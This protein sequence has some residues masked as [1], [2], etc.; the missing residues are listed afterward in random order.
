MTPKD[1]VLVAEEISNIYEKKT[2][3][4][5]EKKVK[6]IR[7]ILEKIF[8][9]YDC[10]FSL[11]YTNSVYKN[12]KLYKFVHRIKDKNSLN[13]KL[14]RKNIVFNL[15]NE[16]SLT[17]ANYKTPT[18]SKLIHE[19]ILNNFDD[20]IGF[21]ILCDL[22]IDVV[23]ALSLIKNKQNEFSNIQFLN[24]SDQPKR[25]KNGLF[26]NKLECKFENVHF[27]LQIKSKIESAWADM[28]HDLYYK[29]HKVDIIKEI[30][31][32]SISH[33]GILLKQIDNY[34]SDLRNMNNGFYVNNKD[35]EFLTQ[36]E[37]RY[38]DSLKS[39]VSDNFIFDFSNISKQLLYILGN[40]ALNNT[41]SNINLRIHL[42]SILNSK[43]K[44]HDS[45]E[46]I[47][48]EAIYREINGDAFEENEYLN[49]YF[50]FILYSIDC[51][52]DEFKENI[53]YVFNNIINS[54]NGSDHLIN[55]EKYEILFDLYK[56]LQE[57]LL[58]YEEN[59][60]FDNDQKNMI[61]NYFGC[62]IF[63]VEK[64]ISLIDE[65]E[66]Q[67][68]YAELNRKSKDKLYKKKLNIL[69]KNFG[70]N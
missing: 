32:L 39:A 21:R 33:T 54:I 55:L 6:R 59:F 58:E 3:K 50:N 49:K 27:E 65:K 34:L 56:T 4:I 26:I 47:I 67:T 36:I 52:I 70:E 8:D 69:I 28:E 30:N 25:M 48:L 17:K 9:K 2:K 23:N 37:N 44:R 62:K 40:N 29:D 14:N 61:F 43:N 41:S 45:W 35:I 5:L 64:S 38:S 11:T 16:L 57:I 12:K 63:N 31:K 15:I 7:E 60:N 66:L 19:N 42:E 20:N 46:M 68:I 24:L 1:I 22:E 18:K 53:L 51:K 10:G 13:E